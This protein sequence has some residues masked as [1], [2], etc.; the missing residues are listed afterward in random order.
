MKVGGLVAAP[1]ATGAEARG[2]T[3]LR[4]EHCHNR[5]ASGYAGGRS[6]KPCADALFGID[7]R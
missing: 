7:D 2:G 3:V 4:C 6:C 1:P 5:P